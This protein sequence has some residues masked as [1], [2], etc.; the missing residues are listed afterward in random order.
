MLAPLVPHVAEELWRALGHDDTITYASFPD[1]DPAFLVD[2]QVEYPV[3]VNGKVRG[4]ITVAADADRAEV[5]RAALA[6]D[7]VVAAI[8]GST[9]TKVIVVPGRMVNIVI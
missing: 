3:Q 2:D 4:R 5:E 9:P 6:D 8:A 1:A 7:K